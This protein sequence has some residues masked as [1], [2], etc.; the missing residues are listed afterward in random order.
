MCHIVLE[1]Y[2]ACIA[3]FMAWCDEASINDTCNDR[4]LYGAVRAFI[5]STC[6]RT[7]SD[8]T[9]RINGLQINVSKSSLYVTKENAIQV[10]IFDSL[11]QDTDLETTKEY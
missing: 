6:E 3:T 1:S 2:T 10:H 8:S 7:E 4:I 5:R 9:F 11:K